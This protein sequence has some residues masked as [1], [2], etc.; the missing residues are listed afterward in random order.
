ML[1]NAKLQAYNSFDNTSKIM[2]KIIME[3]EWH[4]K[5]YQTFNFTI[6]VVLF[7]PIKQ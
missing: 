6:I 5:L 3:T 2:P 1:T 7:R 4:K